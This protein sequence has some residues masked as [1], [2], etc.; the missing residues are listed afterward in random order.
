MKI[1]LVGAGSVGTAVA[2]LL[3]QNGHDVAGVAS[4]SRAS[5]ETAAQRLATTVTEIGDIPEVDLLLL[6]VGDAAIEDV[7]TMI[8]ERVAAGTYVCHFAGSFGT[9]PLS[10]VIDRGGIACAIHPVQACPTIDAAIA[11]L[12]GSAWG[13]TCSTPEGE[14]A[15]T[16]LIEDD[17]GGSAF[18]IDEKV[19]PLWHAAAVMTSNGIAALLATAEHLLA[20][21]G[22][23]EPE[24]VL[25][26]LASG[27][28]ANAIEGGGGGKTLTGPIVRR[29]IET[30]ARH[31]E[32]LAAHNEEHRSDYKMISS[33]IWLA[34][35][36]SGRLDEAEADEVL[37][38]I[39]RSSG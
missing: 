38:A 35:T 34:A 11:R 36:R 1:A 5:A 26:P 27:T 12:P 29:D 25:G 37:D 30:I 31:L 28:V 23:D 16:S 39:T 17:L 15:M 7:A 20:S 3:A 19:R 24:K 8:T 9:E 21:I 2:H 13:V 14:K 32:Y 4:R 6:G 22:I 18:V 10:S 33:L